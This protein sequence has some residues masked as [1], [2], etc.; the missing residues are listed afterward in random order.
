MV[1]HKSGRL[2]QTNKKHKSPADGSRA[3]K[4]SMGA[5]RIEKKKISKSKSSIQDAK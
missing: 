1:Q 5:G 4:K 2:K 3:Q